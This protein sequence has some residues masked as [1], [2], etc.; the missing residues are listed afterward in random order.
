M[1]EILD[2]IKS[3]Q[4]QIVELQNKIGVEV[5]RAREE[6]RLRA[7]EE[8]DALKMDFDKTLGEIEQRHKDAVTSLNEGFDK[9]RLML[10]ETYTANT[11]SILDSN[12]KLIDLNRSL[13]D[14]YDRMRTEY[15]EYIKSHL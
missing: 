3:L 8:K 14:K 2:K 15:N 10:K 7:S 5:A 12:S 1:S 13:Q 11:Q 9:E 4:D 6:E